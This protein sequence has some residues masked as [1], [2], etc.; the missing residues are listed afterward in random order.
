MTITQKFKKKNSLGWYNDYKKGKHMKVYEAG[1]PEAKTVLIQPIDEQSLS[2]IDKQ[3][4][5]IR[6]MTENDFCFKAIIVDNWF[7]DLSPWKSPAVFGKDAFGDGA[8]NTLE[9]ILDL[10]NDGSRTYYI[11]GYSLAAL[12]SLW[13]VYQT[14]I[15]AGVAAASPS[16]WFPGFV[17]YM[18]E[19]DI[20]CK[21][22]Y[23]SLGDKE[24]K[25]K[26]KVMATV[27]DCIMAAQK[28][29]TERDTDCI[30]E[31]NPGNHFTDVGKRCARAFSRLLV[32][33]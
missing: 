10:C 28:I 31:W 6:Q 12:F 13:A 21:R 7:S 24:G 29:L 2:T 3:I 9:Y 26:N 25:T 16:M 19:H 22:V 11:G 32:T 4:A 27:D 5:G 15:F 8:G 1:N 30:F 17:D 14:D 18:K 20:K 23:L 33:K